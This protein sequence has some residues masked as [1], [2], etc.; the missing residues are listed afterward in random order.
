M[1]SSDD[2][3]SARMAALE[4]AVTRN[5]DGEIATAEVLAEAESFYA[6][7]AG[8]P[9]PTVQ[10]TIFENATT[11]LPGSP[12]WRT[13]GGHRIPVSMGFPTPGSAADIPTLSERQNVA[14]FARSQVSVPGLTVAPLT[15][16][17][18]EDIARDAR[19]QHL[20]P[21]RY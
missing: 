13:E 15:E 3:F 8:K 9:A 11:E 17:E 2:D 14:K 10:E 16:G 4:H 12:H 19:V 21:E 1:L 5:R 20:K 18:L 6:F 7:L